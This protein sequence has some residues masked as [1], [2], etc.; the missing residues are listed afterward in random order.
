MKLD[1]ELRSEIASALDRGLG[2]HRIG[3][4]VNSGTVTLSGFARSIAQ[5]Q[6]AERIVRGCP[7]VT[8]IFERITIDCRDGG[9]CEFESV[10]AFLRKIEPLIGPEDTVD[11][12]VEDGVAQLSG[13]LE[14]PEQLALVLDAA[15]RVLA[16]MP[17]DTSFEL[18]RPVSIDDV[19]GRI[20]QALER[21]GCPELYPIK[22][23]VDG[24]R[25]QLGGRVP[26]W[27]ER[28]IVERAALAAK[29]VEAVENSI[30]V[31]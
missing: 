5:K 20:A 15:I 13:L 22:V 12:T 6:A 21:A 17:V 4:T 25:V 26:H 31:G 2:R 14:D 19:E 7:G 3:V 10:Q 27:H 11:V 16:P 8:A 1:T 24:C 30:I 18:R 29:G 9:G 28:E 23:L